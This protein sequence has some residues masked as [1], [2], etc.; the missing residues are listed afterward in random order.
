MARLGQSNGNTWFP[1]RSPW[2]NYAKYNL[3]SR[4]RQ[5]DGRYAMVWIGLLGERAYSCAIRDSFRVSGFLL[6]GLPIPSA[7]C[8]Q[9]CDCR[10][11][12]V[13]NSIVFFR[14]FYLFACVKAT[15][16]SVSVFVSNLLLGGSLERKKRLTRAQ[17][18]GIRGRLIG[19]K[20]YQS[21]ARSTTI[22]KQKIS[23]EVVPRTLS[24]SSAEFFQRHVRLLLASRT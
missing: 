3:I 23:G 12:H 22:Q 8:V 24:N 9:V 19:E 2:S 11:K 10:S 15:T 16:P 1:V 4:H 5:V 18:S 7:G 20:P 17:N 6:P 21:H 14:V 13:G